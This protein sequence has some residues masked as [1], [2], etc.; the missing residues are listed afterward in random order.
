MAVVRGGGHGGGVLSAGSDERVGER[1]GVARH[2]PGPASLLVLVLTVSSTRR[3][4]AVSDVE[5]LITERQSHSRALRSLSLDIKGNVGRGSD[6][7]LGRPQPQSL[8]SQ[9]GRG[10]VVLTCPACPLTWDRCPAPPP[11]GLLCV[12]PVSVDGSPQGPVIHTA[13]PRRP[14]PG[15]PA[16]ATHQDSNGHFVYR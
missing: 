6:P 1:P 11:T 4:L 12:D 16:P 14:C 15:A 7:G 8:R 5:D 9:A 3:I 10:A 2:G 13:P